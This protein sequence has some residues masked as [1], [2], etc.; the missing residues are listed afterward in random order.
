M[1]AVEVTYTEPD[2]V[3]VIRLMAERQTKTFKIMLVLGAIIGT[4]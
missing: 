1:I 2:Y 3:R 4:L